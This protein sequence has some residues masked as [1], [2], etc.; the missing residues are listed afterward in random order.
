MSDIF[1]LS[2][3]EVITQSASSSPTPGGGSVSAIAASFGAAMVAMVGNLTTGKEKFKEVE[4][5]VQEQLQKL[6]GILSRLESLVRADIEAFDAYMAV[7]KMPKDTEE[8]KAARAQAMQ[9]AAK[10]ATNVP[11]TIGET[12]LEALASAVELAVVGNKMAI[13]DVGVGA[14][15]A[16]AA[17]KGAL[18]NVDINLPAIKDE[19]FVAESAARRDRLIEQALALR[20]TAVAE[21]LKR[22][23]G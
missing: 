17:L 5:Q 13:S 14:Y 15:L 1:D 4:P 6:Q 3:R 21:V 20:D 7:F 11:L 19:T 2:L 18:L 10:N 22:I 9:V 16:E 12:C 8:Q 23:R